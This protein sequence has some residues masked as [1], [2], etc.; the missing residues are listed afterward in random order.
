M[1]INNAIR[2][3]VKDQREVYAKPGEV[4]AVDKAGGLIDVRPLDGAAD[5]LGV[6]LQ[7]ESE[8]G[9][10]LALP[11]V[12]SIVCVAFLSDTDALMAAAGEIDTWQLEIE[13][14]KIIADKDGLRVERGGKNL[15]ASLD[16]LIDAVAAIVVVQGKGPDIP[17]LKQIQDD[18][19][20][21]LK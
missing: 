18:F 15:L 8:R 16:A 17:R 10:V 14:T 13:N 11:K 12:G 21:I 7:A 4:I 3:I 2:N 20:T 9:G 1:D 5:V 6:R 19:K